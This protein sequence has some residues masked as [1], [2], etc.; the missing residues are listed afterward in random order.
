MQALARAFCYVTNG[1]KK[2]DLGR[3]GGGGVSAGKTGARR[4][5]LALLKLALTHSCELCTHHSV[6]PHLLGGQAYL[7]VPPPFIT[8]KDS[9]L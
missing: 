3:G 4:D 1:I 5:G 6:G 9:S 8:M 2:E 7:K